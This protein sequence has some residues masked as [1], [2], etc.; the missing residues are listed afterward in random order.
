[1]SFHA[2]AI[3]LAALSTAAPVLAL[4]WRGRSHGPLLRSTLFATASIAFVLL[5]TLR[6]TA[7]EN[8]GGPDRWVPLLLASAV[9]LLLAGFLFSLALG[10]QP[11][12]PPPDARRWLVYFASAGAVFLLGLR[13]PGFVTGFDGEEGHGVIHLGAFGKAYLSYL[14]V[15]AVA[16]GYNLER[17][18]RFASSEARYRLRLPLLGLFAFL[19][20][21][22]FILTTGLLYASLG[23]GKLITLSV[24]AAFASLTLTHGFLRDGLA[25]GSVPSPRNAVY[26][27]F[28]ALAAGLFVIA[29]TAA[30]QVA[31]VAG[32]SPD[33]I[34][35]VTFVLAGAIGGALFVFSH[36]FQR[37]VRRFIDRNF[38]VNR[39][40]PRAQWSALARTLE[41]AIDQPAILSRGAAFLQMA[42]TA[43][44]VTFCLRVE[45]T[46]SIEPVHGKGAA[47]GREP[48]EPESPLVEQLRRERRTLLLDRTPHDLAYIPIYAENRRWLEATAS[49]I[50][51]PLFDGRELLGTVGLERRDPDDPFTYEDAALLDNIAVHLAS[52][53]RSAR[54]AR[55][56][57][58]N[59]E[60][61]LI[62]QWSS[63]LLH[64]L[65]NYLTPLRIAATNLVDRRDDPEAAAICGEDIHRVTDRIEKLVLTLST[66]R[67]RPAAGGALCPNELVRDALSA[68][69]VAARG[70]LSVDL[71]LRS[72]QQIRGNRELLRRVLENLIANA[73]EAMHVGGTLTLRTADLL[74][75][76]HPEVRIRVEDTG[77]GITP[78]FMQEKLFRPFA[79]TKPN[80]LGLGLYQSRAIVRA[81]GGQ[82]TA[83]SRPGAGT[84]FQI[85][86]EAAPAPA[87]ERD[88]S[89]AWAGL[90]R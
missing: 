56:V 72:V 84:A 4:L 83:E 18:Y 41:N 27:S 75:N 61:E 31:T 58:E 8:T 45:S 57:A 88:G 20:F 77:R 19:G 35:L 40:D 76:G 24:P 14:L 68:F 55:E 70:G 46:G 74:G 52:A 69:P 79:T 80:G 64:D 54:L 65:K 62:S 10:R 9:P 39:Y 32:W 17:T 12:P 71:D 43:E 21:G 29:I 25:E 36:R 34:L 47:A 50:V 2:L 82:L 86:L 7:P 51:S 60:M 81:Y 33:Q 1:M 37:R 49:E 23:L 89:P 26:S 63:M 44:A 48:L 3:L 13:L 30:A 38:H 6:L 66:L 42:F 67:N 78:E 90:P 53:L 22:V 28:T 11:G 59:R 73:L 5:A 16:I 87:P 85:D 15:G